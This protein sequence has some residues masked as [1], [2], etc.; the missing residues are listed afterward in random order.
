M[1]I[2]LLKKKSVLII[3]NYYLQLALLYLLSFFIPFLVQGPQLLVG[4]LVNF[5]LILAITQFK[6]KAIIPALILPSLSVYAYGLLFG[7]ATN[8]L[9]YLIPIIAIGN[10]SY[11]LTFQGCQRKFNRGCKKKYITN[12]LGVL[13]AAMVKSI[14]LFICTYILIKSIGLP[15][16]F[17]TAMGVTQL[18]TASIGGHL[19]LGT[20]DLSKSLFH[21][22]HEKN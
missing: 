18:V 6:L 8:F 22:S 20:L 7:G 4:I 13:L 15:Q 16:M 12:Y 11:V 14:L 1:L 2:Q 5:L 19:A 9:I 10:A 17:L 21:S 3:E